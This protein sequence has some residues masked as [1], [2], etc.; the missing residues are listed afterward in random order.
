MS[1]EDP[2]VPLLGFE[3]ASARRAQFLASIPASLL[4][5]EDQLPKTLAHANASAQAKLRRI[6]SLVDEFDEYR[7]GLVAC[8]KGCSACCRMNVQISN[9]EAKQISQTIGRQAAARHVST[10]HSPSKFMGQPCPFL[11]DD[12]CSIYA[13]RPLACRKHVS[14]HSTPEWC[15]PEHALKSTVPGVGFSGLDQALFETSNRAGKAVF[16]DIRDFF[17]QLP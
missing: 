3:E 9:L 15:E 14:F 8:G 11:V 13:N 17:P 16:A 7:R 4:E 1:S 5:Q 2:S 10:V 12:S 6:Y